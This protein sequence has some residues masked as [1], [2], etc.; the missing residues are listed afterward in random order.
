MALLHFGPGVGCSCCLQVALLH[1]GAFVVCLSS[2]RITL[3]Y[4]GP[5][6]D[7]FMISECLRRVTSLRLQLLP[8]HLPKQFGNSHTFCDPPNKINRAISYSFACSIVRFLATI[9]TTGSRLSRLNLRS[10]G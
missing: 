4:L 2:L 3:S 6:T 1:F 7:Y 9:I 5:G 10:H 8:Y